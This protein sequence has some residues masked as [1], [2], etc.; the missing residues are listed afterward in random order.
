MVLRPLQ[1]LGVGSPPPPDCFHT[2]E[3]RVDIKALL[4]IASGAG[5][6]CLTIETQ[7]NR[8]FL[9]DINKITFS[10]GDIEVK[11]LYHKRPLYLATLINQIP[12]KRAAVDTSALLNLIPLSTLQV[13]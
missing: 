6:E 13:A 8:A 12:I 3:R 7:Y 10:D 9:E 11:Y 1:K 2:N 5:V 4:G